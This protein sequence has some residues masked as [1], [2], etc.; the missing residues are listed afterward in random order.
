MLEIK[1]NGIGS[2]LL[3]RFVFEFYYL[4]KKYF[5]LIYLL[6]KEYSNRFHF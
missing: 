2:F 1:K 4:N 3:L 5:N 6:N